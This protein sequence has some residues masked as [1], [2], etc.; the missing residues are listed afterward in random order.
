MSIQKNNLKVLMISTDRNIFVEGSEAH[1]RMLEYGTLVKELHIIIFAKHSLGLKEM[2]MGENIFLYPTNSRSRM[3]YIQD[4]IKIVQR[5]KLGV[6]IVTTQDPFETGLA[7]YF[8]SKK[9]VAPLHLQIHT[10]FL[11]PYF[12]KHSFL[13]VVRIRIAKFL[14]PKARGGIRVVSERIKSSIHDNFQFPFSVFPR[15]DVLPVFVDTEK[16]QNGMP[17]FD[18]HEK[19]PQFNHTIL[20]VSRLEPEKNISFA[21]HLLARTPSSPGSV[22]GMVIVGDG[23]ERKK[24]EAEAKKFGVSDRVIFEGPQSDL[25]S[26]YKT[27]DLFLLTS[28]YEGYGRTLIEAAAAG[29]PVLS[30]DVGV[31]REILNYWNGSVCPAG[32]EECMKRNI[33]QWADEPGLA[34]SLRISA[35]GAVK[36]IPRETKESYLLKY[37]KMWEAAVLGE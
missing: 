5:Q 34:D 7:G 37:Q 22:C 21:L 28:D 1:T 23:G 16:F 19:Y 29:C 10:D 12:T 6:D 36:N 17:S 26:Y 18:L 31:A 33:S 32:D 15:I 9:I 13:N 35:R 24:L 27:A 8:V 11:D 3:G 14:L 30:F 25:V 4:A 2:S 20:M